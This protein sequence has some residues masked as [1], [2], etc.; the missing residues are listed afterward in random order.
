M[1]DNLKALQ[2]QLVKLDSERAK[3][4]LEINSLR[5]K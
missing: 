1:E 4:N 2:E 5:N 3:L